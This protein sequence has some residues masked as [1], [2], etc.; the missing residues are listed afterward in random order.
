MC[1]MVLKDESAPVSQIRSLVSGSVAG[2]EQARLHG[3]EL[4]FLLP[5]DRVTAFP[6]LFNKVGRCRLAFGATF[7]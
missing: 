1:R 2:A 6:P 4:S 3:K 7:I 5:R